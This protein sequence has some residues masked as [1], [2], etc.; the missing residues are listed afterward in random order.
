MSSGGIDQTAEPPPSDIPTL[1]PINTR[2]VPWIHWMIVP[3]VLVLII[4]V[5][6]PIGRSLFLSTQQYNLV[7]VQPP[8]YVG[9]KNFADLASDRIFWQSLK[10]TAIYS[11]GGVAAAAIL[12]LFLALITENLRGF[13]SRSLRTVLILPWA[14]PGVV[15]AF[16]FRYMY[17]QDGGIVNK[18]LLSLR[19][20]AHPVPWLNSA[21]ISLPA[22]MVAS[23]WTLTPFFFLL[24]SAGLSGIPNEVIESARVDRTG[25][26]AMIYHIK[27]PYLRN[28]LLIGGLLMVIASFNDFGSIWAM[29]Q[30]GPGY[31]TSTLVI[32]IYRIAFEQ[33]QFGYASATGVIWLLLLL[34]FTMIYVR[35]LRSE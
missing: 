24:L 21:M 33:F 2:Q 30:G 6:Y 12:G 28:H 16:L 15:A 8:R 22:V 32:Y 4:V 3:T 20:I 14:M 19:V 18:V 26:I 29:T 7:D 9:L 11:F 13:G 35:T 5:G 25:T 31:A 10:N 27:L 1:A 34:G 17:L 23:I